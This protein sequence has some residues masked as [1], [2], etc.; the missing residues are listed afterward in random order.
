MKRLSERSQKTLDLM[1][2]KKVFSLMKD[3]IGICHIVEMCDEVYNIALSVE[4]CQD[5]AHLFNELS[6]DLT[7]ID[8][9][10]P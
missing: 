10:M 6:Q 8:K 4:L 3:E 9:P 7:V 5:L 1:Q 2:K